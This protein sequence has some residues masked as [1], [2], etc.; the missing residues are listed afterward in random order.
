MRALRY[1]VIVAGAVGFG[2]AT[3]TNASEVAN[4]A[5]RGTLRPSAEV[6]YGDVWG[7]GNLLLLTTYQPAQSE[8][9]G[10]YVIDASNPD[11]LSLSGFLPTTLSLRDVTAADTLCLLSFESGYSSADPAVMLVSIADP[12]APRTLGTFRSDSVDLAHNA[13]LAPPYAY[14]ASS[15]TGDLRIIDFSDPAEPVEVGRWATN[16]EGHYLHDVLVSDS[17]AYLCYWEDGLVILSVADP[18]NPY[19]VGRFSYPLA[20]THSVAL[21]SDGKTAYVADE[22]F[23][24]PYGGLRVLDISDPSAIVEVATWRCPGADDTIHNVFTRGDRLFVSYYTCGI[25][26]LDISSPLAPREIA[27]HDVDEPGEPSGGF[28]GVYPATDST[29][30]VYASHIEK[31]AFVFEQR[32]FRSLNVGAGGAAEYAS[33][34]AAMSVAGPGDTIRVAPGVFRENVVLRAGVTLEGSGTEV[35][36]LDGGDTGRP[37]TIGASD[38][39]TRVA[40]LTLLGGRPPE[41]EGG[42]ALLLTGSQ[43]VLEDIVIAGNSA[44]GDGGGALIEGGAPEFRG[45]R[46]ASNRARRGGAVAIAPGIVTASVPRFVDCEFFDNEAVEGGGA[47]FSNAPTPIALVRAVIA[48]NHAQRGGAIAGDVAYFD[49]TN[50]VAAWN[51]ATIAGGAFASDVTYFRAQNC[52]IANNSAPD[53]AAVAGEGAVSVAAEFYDTVVSGNAGATTFHAAG[54]ADVVYSSCDFFGNTGALTGGTFPAPDTSGGNTFD[55]PRFVNPAREALDFLPGIGSAL[56]DAGGRAVPGVDRDSTAVDIGIGGGPESGWIAPRL[57]SR[58]DAVPLDNYDIGIEWT[59]ASTEYSRV[60]IFRDSDDSVPIEDA[61]RVGAFTP[62]DF[63]FD[64]ARTGIVD[65]ALS[66]SDTLVYYRAVPAD[67]AGHS[68]SAGTAFSAVPRNLAPDVSLSLR[69]PQTSTDAIDSLE[70]RFQ[71]IDEIDSVALFVDGELHALQIDRKTRSRVDGRAAFRVGTGPMVVF[72]RAI[73]VF[74]AASADSLRGELL[75]VSD[76]LPRNAFTADRTMGI[77]LASPGSQLFLWASALD[78]PDLPNGM[79]PLS[80]GFT[81]DFLNNSGV[82]SFDVVFMGPNETYA[83]EAVVTLGYIPEIH[84][85]TRVL[86]T[87]ARSV[88]LSVYELFAAKRGVVLAGS[89][90]VT[91]GVDAVQVFAPRPNPFAEATRVDFQIG[92]A[93]GYVEFGIFDTSGRRVRELIRGALPAGRYNLEWNGRDDAGEPAAAGHYFLRAQTGASMT[94]RHITLVR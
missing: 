57:P 46:F 38:P 48:R 13:W 42:G 67:D 81:L 28:W 22:I 74:G 29:G 77:A 90:A 69:L 79:R 21:S 8:S 30:I 54:L 34:S 94:T 36:L 9:N 87:A 10:L 47:I 83:N 75:Q 71:I 72:L 27:Y 88:R 56:I 23:T 15:R 37:L 31:G 85:S 55:D 24:A 73:D 64:R 26:V 58:L 49:L 6:R 33:I 52:V 32:T 12:S 59:G 92:R 18:A 45:V 16:R 82:D 2:A 20:R 50:C 62:Y 5:L 70:V 61:Q 19:E 14:L 68:G 1:A 44:G 39:T 4:L 51:R 63:D 80:R 86:G 53:G 78:S 3:A 76:S 17:L 89:G 84:P 35:T 25:R 7:A 93:D 11:S 60:V 91:S 41:S 65:T 66:P 40:R 43:A